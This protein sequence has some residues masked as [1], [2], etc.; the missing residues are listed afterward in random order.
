LYNVENV[1]T[2][3]WIDEKR[4]IVRPN[5]V[6]F[7]NDTFDVLAG[8]ESKEHRQALKKWVKDDNTDY[9]FDRNSFPEQHSS[10]SRDQLRARTQYKLAQWLYEHGYES[11]ARDHF[12]GAVSLAP[13]DVAIRRGSMRMRGKNPMGLSFYWMVLKRWW[14]G[15]SYYNPIGGA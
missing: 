8:L 15:L 12:E 7:G 1:P 5:D 11:K 10:P 2:G 9:T 13:D 6:V 3:I 4:N 14:N